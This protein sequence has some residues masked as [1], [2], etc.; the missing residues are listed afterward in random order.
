[1]EKVSNGVDGVAVYQDLSFLTGYVTYLIKSLVVPYH[2]KYIFGFME[3][4]YFSSQTP[5]FTSAWIN[6][7][8]STICIKIVI[9]KTWIKE[10]GKKLMMLYISNDILKIA[11]TY[12][13]QIHVVTYDFW[14]FLSPFLNYASNNE[15]NIYFTMESTLYAKSWFGADFKILV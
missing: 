5:S 3:N 11:I 6:N 10:N 14:F 1:M 9:R 15:K 7:K 12:N 4:L 13:F 8:F 2:I